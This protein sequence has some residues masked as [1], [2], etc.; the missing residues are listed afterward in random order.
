M[1]QLRRNRSSPGADQLPP[2]VPLAFARSHAIDR[3]WA[4]PHRMRDAARSYR[5]PGAARAD[6]TEPHVPRGAF[7][8]TRPVPSQTLVA[9]L[10]PPLP[11]SSQGVL[12]QKEEEH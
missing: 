7:L 4:L 12:E 6:I 3:S 9:C 1:R 11:R 10:A 2:D 5:V 8:A